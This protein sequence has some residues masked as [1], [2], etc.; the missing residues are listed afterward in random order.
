[1]TETSRSARTCLSLAKHA[2]AAAEDLAA[3]FLIERGLV[4][5]ARNVR[6]RGGEI[7]L[8][9]QDEESLVLLEVR[10]RTNRE[11]GGAPASVTIGKQRELMRAARFALQRHPEWRRRRMRFDVIGIQGSLHGTHGLQW[12]RDAFGGG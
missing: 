3:G 6:C 7:D 11:F 8:V 12:I 1:M 10:H 2:G 5:L 9:C 4:L